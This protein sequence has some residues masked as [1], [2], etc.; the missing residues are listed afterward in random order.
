[1]CIDLIQPEKSREVRS[2]HAAI[3][4]VIARDDSPIEWAAM[5]WALATL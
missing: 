1:M 3:T 5:L 2:E 4:M